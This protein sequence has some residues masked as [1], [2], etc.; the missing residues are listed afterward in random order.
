MAK[1]IS[2]RVEEYRQFNDQVAALRQL[3]DA[4]VA[5]LPGQKVRYIICD[6][7]SGDYRERVK[8]ADLLEGDE[9][10]DHEKYAELLARAGEDLLGG[11]CG[12]GPSIPAQLKILGYGH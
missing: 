11:L 2:H 7:N 12:N 1:R 9:K 8:V 4:G 5:M 6:S 3:H 10:Y